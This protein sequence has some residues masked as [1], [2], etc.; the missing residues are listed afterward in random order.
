M[1]AQ[2]NGL[3][4]LAVDSAGNLYVA[5]FYNQVVRKISNGVI[6]TVAGN[7]TYGYSGDKGLATSAQLAGPSGIAVDYL[8]SLYIAEGYNNTIRKV[9]NGVITTVAG[10]GVAGF[11]GDLGL[12]TSAM[13]H[14]PTDVALDSLSNFYIADNGNNRVRMVAF[15]RSHDFHHSRGRRGTLQRRARASGHRMFAVSPT[16]RHRSGRQRVHRGRYPHS[17]GL[18][19]NDQHHRGGRNSGGRERSAASAQLASPQGV[20]LDAA[21]NVYISDPGTGQVLKVAGSTLRVAGTGVAQGAQTDNVPATTALL[22]TPTGVAADGAGDLFV[23]DLQNCRLRKVS[24]GSSPRSRAAAPSWVTAD[25]PLK[26]NCSIRRASPWML[27]AIS[28]WP[29]STASAWS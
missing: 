12:S 26:L 7:G 21:G 1:N 23:T 24:N 17:Q 20:T 27:G 19:R 13:L 28:I 3:G 4:A 6:T 14:Q 11:N 18:S 29:I 5:D 9:S 25:R 10:T 15:G 16:R 2:F 8:G 22:G